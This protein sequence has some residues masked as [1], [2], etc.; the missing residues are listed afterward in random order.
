MG[1]LNK[2]K[3]KKDKDADKKKQPE[4]AEKKKV[5][6]KIE[7]PVKEKAQ[8][9]QLKKKDPEAY[10]ILLKPL[11]TEKATDLSAQNQYA[12]IVSEKANKIE[13]AKKIEHVYGVTPIKVRVMNF[14]GKRVRY[15]RVMGKTKGWK[16]AIVTLKPADKIE[17]Y[18]G[19]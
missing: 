2:I 11:I 10:K 7:K 8:K 5:E 15:G 19:V 9:K 12:F 14:S 6:K 3:R 17:I 1:L 16:K 4:A 18:E 13:I